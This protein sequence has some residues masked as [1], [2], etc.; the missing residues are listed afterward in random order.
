MPEARAE[1]ECER[2]V[3]GNGE[4]VGRDGLAG[5]YDLL[6]GGHDSSISA[7]FT[8]GNGILFRAKES[9]TG[10]YGASH[11][12]LTSKSI[13]RT[14]MVNILSRIHQVNLQIFGPMESAIELAI[15]IF[16]RGLLNS[17]DIQSLAV[18]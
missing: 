3:G 17:D 1:F 13:S 7:Y 2:W 9:G 4:D 6:C 8:L 15:L 11:P 10:G 12:S 16:S 18:S 14:N 5:E